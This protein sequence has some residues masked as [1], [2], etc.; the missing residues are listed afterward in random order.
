MLLIGYR[1]GYCNASDQLA[2][3]LP[4]HRAR[5]KPPLGRAGGI[6]LRGGSPA[7]SREAVRFSG[8]VGEGPASNPCLSQGAR[9]HFFD[10][11][12]G[13][14]GRPPGAL[15]APWRR[16]TG[17]GA[18]AALGVRGVGVALRVGLRPPP[19]RRSAVW[20]GVAPAPPLGSRGD[21][22]FCDRVSGRIR[23]GRSGGRGRGGV[24]LCRR[25]R[26]VVP[27][28]GGFVY[29]LC[30]VVGRLLDGFCIVLNGISWVGA[31][32]RYT[33]AGEPSRVCPQV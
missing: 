21:F 3:D 11:R 9:G 8:A 32:Q 29:G 5:L 4:R 14:S 19:P 22:S 30:T 23:A 33:A 20:R 24:L 16:V 27:V 25:L 7:A 18:G 1:G 31:G 6:P 17:G 28:L 15:V 13:P 2:V 26:I 12:G 10:S